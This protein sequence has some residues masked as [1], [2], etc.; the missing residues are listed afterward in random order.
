MTNQFLDEHF[1]AD[2]RGADSLFLSLSASPCASGKNS[3]RGSSSTAANIACVAG[4]SLRGPFRDRPRPLGT[5]RVSKQ[6]TLAY[7]YR[8]YVPRKDSLMH[9]TGARARARSVYGFTPPPFYFFSYLR[10]REELFSARV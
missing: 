7:I 5:R 3:R 4:T 9:G 2:R 10:G 1:L 6:I 8:S